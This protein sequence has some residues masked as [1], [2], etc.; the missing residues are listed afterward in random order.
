MN[1]K[2]MTQDE[3]TMNFIKMILTSKGEITD[4]YLK[5]ELK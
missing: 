3:E 4:E 1:N 2:G 5:F